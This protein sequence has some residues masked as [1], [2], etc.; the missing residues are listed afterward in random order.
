M[1]VLAPGLARLLAESLYYN[2]KDNK[3]LYQRLR[4]YN[5]TAVGNRAA[6][7]GSAD[8]NYYTDATTFRHNNAFLGSGAAVGVNTSGNWA[9]DGATLR[10]N[11]A[12]DTLT[13]A[14]GTASARIKFDTGAAT[15]TDVKFVSYEICYRGTSF[16]PAVVDRDDT[17]NTLLSDGSNTYWRELFRFSIPGNGDGT[18]FDLSPGESLR[19][20]GL[21]VRCY[22]AYATANFRV[23]TITGGQ[24]F[25]TSQANALVSGTQYYAQIDTA[26]P[27][28]PAG[29]RVP[30][31]FY[32]TGDRLYYAGPVVF[33]RYPG[34]LSSVVNLDI[35]TASTGG[36]PV[37]TKGITSINLSADDIPFLDQTALSQ[38]FTIVG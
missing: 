27:S 22:S 31:Q 30:I 15:W 28:A 13:N 38:Y 3:Y 34:A 11:Y 20:A 18:A 35:Y 8:Y 19:L 16:T 14:E 1:L 32:K 6:T 2:T 26:S 4:V 21:Y 33:N 24:T 12:N 10:L 25:T 17:G 36:S 23:C 7:D 5:G 29:V 37:Y 9:G